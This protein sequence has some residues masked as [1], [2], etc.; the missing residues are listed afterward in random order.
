[1][2]ERLLYKFSTGEGNRMCQGIREVEVTCDWCDGTGEASPKGMR[3]KRMEGIVCP[4]C[5][6]VGKW[7]E[8]R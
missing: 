1:M 7:I 8:W 6:G 3:P 2:S 5:L 4:K